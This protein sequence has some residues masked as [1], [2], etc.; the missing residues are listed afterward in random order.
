M[1]GIVG[2]SGH[3]SEVPGVQQLPSHQAG[4]PGLAFALTV[5]PAQSAQT[6]LGWIAPVGCP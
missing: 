3:L 4:Q 2:P 1:R 6:A 5:S